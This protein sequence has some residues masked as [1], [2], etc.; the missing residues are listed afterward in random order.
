[1][2]RTTRLGSYSTEAPGIT[3]RQLGERRS[4]GGAGLVDHGGNLAEARGG[5][6]SSVPETLAGVL[7]YW[8]AC[9]PD[10]PAL[11]DPLGTVSYRELADMAARAGR[12]LAGLGLRRDSRVALISS[13]GPTI[14][15]AFPGIA[16]HVPCALIDPGSSADTCRELFQRLRIEAV[17]ADRGGM[18][19][20]REAA[21][22]LGLAVLDVGD[23]GIAT[24]SALM[25]SEDAAHELHPGPDDILL[26]L[27]SSGTTGKSK[28]IPR[29]HRRDIFVARY[30]AEVLDIGNADICLLPMPLY[31]SF[32][33]VT[34]QTVL[35]TGSACVSLGRFRLSE[36]VEWA[37]RASATW[38]VGAPAVQGELVRALEA[39]PR[40]LGDWRPRLTRSTGAALPVSVASAI[41][42]RI[43]AKLVEMYGSTEAAPMGGEP[44][45]AANK[46][47]SAGKP[48]ANE[49]AIWDAE[50]RPVPAGMLGEIA[51]RGPGVVA[52]YLDDPVASAAAFVNGWFRSG[53]LGRLDED[54]YLYLEGRITDIINRGGSK[55]APLE[56]EQWLLA[57]PGVAVAVVFGVPLPWLG[58]D[59]VAAIVQAPNGHPEPAAL[60]VAML[61]AMPGYKVP[62][63]ILVVPALPLTSLGKVRRDGLADVL[64]EAMTRPHRAPATALE[65]QIAQLFCSVLGVEEVGRDDDFIE[66]GGHSLLA[67]LMLG[68][69]EQE[70]GHRVKL[71]EF[72]RDP[73]VAGLAAI[74]GASRSASLHPAIEPYRLAGSGPVLFIAPGVDGH[75]YAVH[76]LLAH[77]PPDWRVA[78]IHAPDGEA[79]GF[80]LVRDTAAFCVERLREVQPQGPYR[81]AGYSLGGNIAQEMACQLAAAGEAIDL[82]CLIDPDAGLAQ[83]PMAASDIRFWHQGASAR[84]P[85][86]IFGGRVVLI[87]SWEKPFGHLSMPGRGWEHLSAGGVAVFDLPTTHWGL[88]TPPHVARIGQVLAM[89][90]AGDGMPVPDVDLP[91]SPLPEGYFQARALLIGSQPEAA[92]Q[93]LSHCPPGSLPAWTLELAGAIA[94][95]ATTPQTRHAALNAILPAIAPNGLKTS[96]TVP[97][98]MAQGRYAEALSALYRPALPGVADETILLARAV[99]AWKLG[100]VKLAQDALDRLE[101][102]LRDTPD[103]CASVHFALGS[104]GWWDAAQPYSERVVTQGSDAARAWVL[105]LQAGLAVERKDWK[106]AAELAGGAVEAFPGVIDYTAVLVGALA[107][108]GLH[109]QAREQQRLVKERFPYASPFHREIERAANLG[110]PSST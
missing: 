69:L 102:S 96:A 90:V 81:L 30:N 18:P 57:Q 54:G 72:I 55:V 11:I 64:R 48:T 20:A 73:S 103:R 88:M 13:S 33:I 19:A 94:A 26:I 4:A 85:I 87:R 66:L 14:A 38:Y 47:G 61:A 29:T 36:F 110:S 93:A 95:Q 82:L 28:L 59:V 6:N 46:P 22:Q 21:R 65:Q 70:T 89:A 1:M 92:L 76:P 80:D 23:E 3:G 15:R 32:G 58:E 91:F 105:G 53:D 8:A 60:R 104:A 108:Q 109:E 75:P 77:L 10:R 2:H 42:N 56:V 37:E 39:D 68:R 7:Q 71:A 98:D 9:Q 45:F 62:S 31:H 74:L 97:G 16:S 44:P 86:R 99:C 27:L 78:G 100:Q 106:R 50:G 63:R 5:P 40:A 12:V 52:G 35:L 67:L 34:F 43:G 101:T 107:M 24:T 25:G 49:V 84:H 51:V 83:A 79:D 41:R 17:A